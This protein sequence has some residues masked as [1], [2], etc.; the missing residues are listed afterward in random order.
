MNQSQLDEP[1]AAFRV[2]RLRVPV[3]GGTSEPE[4]LSPLTS[5]KWGNGET[6]R[7]VCKPFGNWSDPHTAAAAPQWDCTCGIYGS[8][9]LESAKELCAYAHGAVYGVVVMWGRVIV[10]EMGYR[11]EFARPVAL[12]AEPSWNTY[13]YGGDERSY[14]QKHAF[15]KYA[16]NLNRLAENYGLPRLDDK[17]LI[18]AAL[19]AGTAIR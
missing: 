2:W 7:A 16:R 12:C 19:D 9:E 5:V 15:K 11:A 6:V 3:K 13:T 10:C 8:R 14:A 4:L 18:R 1:I 17:A